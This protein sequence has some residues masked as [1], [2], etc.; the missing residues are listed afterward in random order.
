MKSQKTDVSSSFTSDCLLQGP[1]ILFE[2]LA[3]VFRGWMMHGSVTHT[4]LACAFLPLLK[5]SKPPAETT[6]YR[7]IAG[8]SLILKLF[9]KTVLELWGNLL[10]SDGLQF[11]YKKGASTT[12][13]TWLVQE[14]VQHYLRNGCNPIVGVLD[15]SQAFDLARWD[16][17][18]ERLLA[19]LPAIVV[20]V[21]IYSYQNQHAW[22]RWGDAKSDR[23]SVTNGTRQGSV[24]SPDAWSCYT[25]PLLHR[26]RSLGV[27]CHLGGL[28]MGAILYSDDQLLIAPNRRAMELM[29]AEVEKFALESNINF[30]TDPDPAKSKSKLIFICGRQTGLPKPASLLLCGRPLPWVSTASHLGHELHESGDMKHDAF[31]KRAALIGKSVEV[32]ESFSFASPSSVLRALD[33]YCSSYYGTLAGWDLSGPEAQKF[34]GVWRM[35]VLLTHNLPRGTHRYFLPLLA[36]GV[37]SAKT[38]ILARFVR[39]FRSL[40]NSQSHEVVTAALL[41]A[42]D[43]RTSLGQNIAFIEELSGRDIWETSPD[44]MRSILS[45]KETV[46]PPQEDIWRIPYLKKLLIQREELH[47]MGM[48]EEKEKLQEIIDSLCVS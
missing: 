37:V 26:L 36:P 17:L 2:M 25:D 30:S 3:S 38:E 29:L 32:R 34:Y 41:C 27:G 33:V 7:A 13:A 44:L 8:S 12:Q 23:F 18:F 20:R 10:H 1:D 39:F 15:C 47:V 35:N 45:E 42:R 11:G 40:R 31:T 9:E 16:Q 14:V 5:S 21:L 48:E 24:F 19:R 46:S 28:F 4:V 43:R 6:S 22:V